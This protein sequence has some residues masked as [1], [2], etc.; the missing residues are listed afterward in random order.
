[1]DMYV[2]VLNLH[3]LCRDPLH[4]SRPYRRNDNTHR[5]DAIKYKKDFS[6]F[7]ELPHDLCSRNVLTLEIRCYGNRELHNFEASICHKYFFMYLEW[8]YLSK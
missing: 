6:L 2:C 1:M 4:L 5:I 8:Y 7:R 3:K